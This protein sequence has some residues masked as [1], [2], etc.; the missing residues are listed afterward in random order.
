MDTMEVIMEDIMEVI[1]VDMAMED[2]LLPRLTTF[3]YI[4][5]KSKKKKRR[6]KKL[7]RVR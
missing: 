7:K 5:M 4:T 3:M 2:T 1:M 6:K